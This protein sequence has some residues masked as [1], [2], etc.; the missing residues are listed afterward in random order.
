MSTDDDRPDRERQGGTALKERPKL[1]K[2]PMYKV[3]LHNDDYTTREFVVL[4]LRDVFRL[5]DSDAVQVMMHVHNTGIGVAGVFTHE[6]AE[7]KVDK[8]MNL[9]RKFEFPLQLTLEAE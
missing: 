1:K 7:A 8:C 6:V 5:S 2:P 4:I 9:A 3:L